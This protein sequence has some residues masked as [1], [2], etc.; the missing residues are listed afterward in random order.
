LLNKI[1]KIGYIDVLLLQSDAH[2]R[3]TLAQQRKEYLKA[4][5]ITSRKELGAGAASV[6]DWRV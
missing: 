2:L 4:A 5:L 1:I 6:L 3:D